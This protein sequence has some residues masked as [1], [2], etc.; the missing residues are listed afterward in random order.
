[1]VRGKILYLLFWR[2]IKK[3]DENDLI[4]FTPHNLIRLVENSNTE[5]SGAYEVPQ[6]RGKLIF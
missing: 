1:M 5:V 2:V 4:F 6:S 3:I